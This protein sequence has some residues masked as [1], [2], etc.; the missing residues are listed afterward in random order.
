MLLHSSTNLAPQPRTTMKPTTADA[1]RYDLAI[2]GKGMMGSAAARHAAKISRDNQQIVL[3]GPSEPSSD[4]CSAAGGVGNSNS[5]DDASTSIFGAHHDEGRIT[6]RTDCDPI[7]AELA[8]RSISRYEEIVQESGGKQEFYSQCGHL[9]V[10]LDD[11]DMISK[12]R[13]TAEL[14]EVECACLDEAAL[15]DEFPHLTFP[16]GCVGLHEK[17]DSGYISARGLV[18]AQTAAA[19]TLGVHVI[20]EIANRVEK[21]ICETNGD[22][23]FCIEVGPEHTVIEA[24]KVLVAAG[25]FCNARPLLPKKLEL[26]PIKTQTVHFVLLEDDAERLKDMPSIIVKNDEL[27][28]YILPP[29]R[30][31]DGTI[32]LKLGGSYLDPYGNE[33]GPNREMHSDQEVVDWYQSNGSEDAM[34]TMENMLRSFVPNTD[35]MSILS[36]SCATLNTPTRQA[37]IGEIEDGWAV[38]TGGNGSAAKSSDELGRLAATCILDKRAFEQ[39]RICGKLCVEVFR[40]R[41][42]PADEEGGEDDVPTT[43]QHS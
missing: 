29:I 8:S 10:G 39:E 22:E 33:Y 31:P 12:R 28:A 41:S 16:Q 30:Y 3:I 37:Y 35:P 18:V 21:R 11:G 24:N 38:A 14:M 23:Y 43:I 42:V 17:K 15:V 26:V 1:R 19:Q 7:W 25:A 5:R 6:R 2:I 9:A 32:R 13:Q 34:R 40:P 4:P 27:W 20:D 36:N